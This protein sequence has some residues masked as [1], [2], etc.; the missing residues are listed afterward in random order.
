MKNWLYK[1]KE[2]IQHFKYRKKLNIVLVLVGLLPILLI[3]GYMWCGF[4]T[5]LME[6][7]Y[8]ALEV[9][10]NQSCLS[11]EKQT[12]I[13]ENLANYLVFDLDLQDVLLAEQTADYDSFSKYSEVVDPVLGA[14]KFYHESIERVTIY[15]EKIRIPHDTTLAPLSEISGMGWFPGL[16]DSQKSLWVWPDEEHKDILLIRKFPGQELKDVYLGIYCDLGKLMESLQYFE[17][18]ESGILLL[19]E[20]GNVLLSKLE[21]GMK[22]GE[23]VS[24]GMGTATGMWRS[25]SAVCRSGPMCL[26]ENRRFTR[27]FM[28]C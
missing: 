3:G 26:R 6:K 21:A 11:M 10:L 8:E 25:G 1:I 15:S 22:A 19:D 13:F 12:E 23:K 4:R 5:L 17:K 24:Q 16:S 9:A 2:Q 14:P 20:Q 18:K 27:D 28:T 7:E